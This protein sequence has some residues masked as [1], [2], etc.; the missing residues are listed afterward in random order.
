[1]F[2]S[3]GCIG[4]VQPNDKN[5]NC[6]PLNVKFVLEESLQLDGKQICVEG[7]VNNS[8][9]DTLEPKLATRQNR[10]KKQYYDRAILLVFDDNFDFIRFTKNSKVIIKGVIQVNHNCWDAWE[11]KQ[12]NTTYDLCV[13]FARPVDL[14]VQEIIEN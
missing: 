1:M 14:I 2:S 11:I 4:N 3:F 8:R 7:Y 12:K 9:Y 13:P 6:E 5:F 10:D